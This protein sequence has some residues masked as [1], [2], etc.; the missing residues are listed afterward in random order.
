M[1]ER[2]LVGQLQSRMEEERHFIQIVVG[3]RQ[4]GKTTAVSQS[5]GN[6]AP[7]SQPSK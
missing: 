1:F 6:M 5:L 4:T 7:P 2:K 3:P